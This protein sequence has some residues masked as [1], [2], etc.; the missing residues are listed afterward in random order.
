MNY[1]CSPTTRWPLAF[2]SILSN[3]VLFLKVC[4]GLRGVYGSEG[5]WPQASWSPW[6][7]G[8]RRHSPGKDKEI[9]TFNPTEGAKGQGEPKALF[10]DLGNAYP[11]Y[12][13]SGPGLEEVPGTQVWELKWPHPWGTRRGAQPGFLQLCSLASP[14][15]ILC[16]PCLNVP[17]S[18][19]L[20]QKGLEPTLF[21]RPHLPADR[22][23][24]P[25]D[26]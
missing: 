14:T 4:V 13:G 7:G 8:S 3:L 21:R 10:V 23:I 2:S 15:L 25:P 5:I 20:K 11:P 16:W 1:P 19:L 12:P 17:L 26:T 6:T 22:S 24:R 18:P 9:H